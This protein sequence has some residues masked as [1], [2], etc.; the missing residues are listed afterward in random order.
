MDFV[1]E[2]CSM[3]FVRVGGVSMVTEEC[4]QRTSQ[5]LVAHRGERNTTN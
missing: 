2:Q 4:C 1:Y 3:D 5:W